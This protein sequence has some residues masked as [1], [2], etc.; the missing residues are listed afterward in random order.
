MKAESQVRKL[1]MFRKEKERNLLSESVQNP[2]R[3]QKTK[4]CISRPQLQD[5]NFFLNFTLI[6]W[7]T[8]KWGRGREA[9]GDETKMVI[10]ES[11]DWCLIIEICDPIHTIV[12]LNCQ[13]P[14]FFF[15]HENVLVCN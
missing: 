13:Y 8:E 4:H 5:S 11:A 12:F 10:Y 14:T 15:S 9:R 3:R 1:K 2:V 7:L 6:Y